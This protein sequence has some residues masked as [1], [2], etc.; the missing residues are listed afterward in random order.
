MMVSCANATADLS[1]AHRELGKHPQ[2]ACSGLL[3][4]LNGHRHRPLVTVADRSGPMLGARRGAAGEGH[5]V[6]A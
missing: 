5:A 3:V 4:Q 2:T 1:V 6:R